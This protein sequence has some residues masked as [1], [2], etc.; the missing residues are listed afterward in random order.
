MKVRRR[1]LVALMISLLLHTGIVTAPGWIFPSRDDRSHPHRVA[2]LDAW[3]QQPN[4][5]APSVP[6]PAKPK[7]AKP[8]RAKPVPNPNA[9][10]VPNMPVPEP[11]VADQASAPEPPTSAPPA[12]EPLT[13][14]PAA[15]APDVPAPGGQLLSLHVRIEYNV[16]RG[17][18]GLVVGQSVEEIDNDGKAYQMRTTTGT[19]GLARLFKRIDMVYTSVGDIVDGHLRPRLFT[20]ERDGKPD[21]KAVF[22]WRQ[23]PEVWIGE[24]RY[25]LE[26][27]TQ[28]LQSVFFEL[29]LQPIVGSSVTLPV[30]TGKKVERY[31]FAVIG[32]EQLATPMGEQPTVH[33]RTVNTKPQVTDVWLGLD[34]ARLPIRIRHLDHQGEIFDQVATSIEAVPNP[35][36]TH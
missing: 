31:K 16:I 35:G 28:D 36:G 24:Y 10:V 17:T 34:V 1:F 20:A 22:D 12:P 26:P 21:V 30:A 18:Q 23:E 2:S 32:N 33:L 14:P 19:T 7:R 25:P 15:V 3:L 9:V 4:K 6:K 13:L 8:R 5:P 11:A 29:A 27:G